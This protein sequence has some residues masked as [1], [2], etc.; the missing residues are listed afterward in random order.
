MDLVS[1]SSPLVDVGPRFRKASGFEQKRPG[2]LL[3]HAAKLADLHRRDESKRRFVAAVE[4]AKTRPRPARRMSDHR[5]RPG[6]VLRVALGVPAVDAGHLRIGPAGVD[7]ERRYSAH[8][9]Y[10][11]QM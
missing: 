3:K 1:D 5:P 4:M 10:F 9:K 6:V 11:S 8:S 2:G 7:V